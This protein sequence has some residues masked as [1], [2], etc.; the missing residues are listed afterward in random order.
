MEDEDHTGAMEDQVRALVV[1]S[2]VEEPP[3]PKGARPV[4]IRMMIRTMYE[5]M[6]ILIMSSNYYSG[7]PR[8]DQGV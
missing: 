6:S 7:G 3:V 5:Y 1:E 2:M 8:S 4:V